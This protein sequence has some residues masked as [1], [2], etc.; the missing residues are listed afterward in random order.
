MTKSL[1]S[2]PPTLQYPSSEFEFETKKLS[3]N[4]L[5][6]ELLREIR[7]SNQQSG[8][9]SQLKSPVVSNADQLK[10]PTNIDAKSKLKSKAS[11]ERTMPSKIADEYPTK[12]KKESVYDS[13]HGFLETKN[14]VE[15]RSNRMNSRRGNENKYLSC[16][17]NPCE[18]LGQDYMQDQV[19]ES[20]PQNSKRLVELHGRKPHLSPAASFKQNFCTQM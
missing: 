19:E 16:I 9:V 2:H 7:L 12:Q 4:D 5:R 14:D 17:D 6:Y 18:S 10:Y 1:E 8:S 15:P 3:L 11:N 13:D 20:K